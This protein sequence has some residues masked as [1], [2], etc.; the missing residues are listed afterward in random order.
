MDVMKLQTEIDQGEREKY[1][2]E[3]QLSE[4]ETDYKLYIKKA[5]SLSPSRSS[6]KRAEIENART[7]L[8]NL[9][10]QLAIIIKRKS[11]L[12]EE[13]KSFEI[14]EKRRYETTIETEKSLLDVK[15]QLQDMRSQNHG[16]ERVNTDLREAV[17]TISKDKQ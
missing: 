4:M 3:L 6:A 16:L 17:K 11:I 2:L 9:Q 13:L 1:N 5:P 10:T 8:N 12:L 14:Y 15:R 7:D